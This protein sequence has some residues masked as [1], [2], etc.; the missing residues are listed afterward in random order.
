MPNREPSSSRSTPPLAPFTVPEPS[1]TGC[2][3]ASVSTPKILAAGAA[4]TRDTVVRRCCMS[5]VMASCEQIAQGA[6]QRGVVELE[7]GRTQHAVVDPLRGEQQG[8]GE[9]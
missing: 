7:V 4:M 2:N 1:M 8:V 5:T 9:L 6:V 3:E